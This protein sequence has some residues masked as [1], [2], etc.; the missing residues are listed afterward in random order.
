MPST[1]CFDFLRRHHHAGRVVRVAQIEEADLRGV[2]VGRIDH[3]RDV[4][5]V[6]LEQRQLDRVRLDVGGVL[7][8]RAVGRVG[9]DY[10]LAAHQERRADHLQ[11]FARSRGEQDVLRLHAMMLGDRFDDVAIGIAVPVG[12]LPRAVHRLHHLLRRAPVVL[13][14]GELDHAVVIRIVAAKSLRA[15]ERLRENFGFGPQAQCADG[16]RDTTK[17]LAAGKLLPDVHRS[18]PKVEKC[19]HEG[20]LVR[21]NFASQS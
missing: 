3:P 16:C 8:H 7:I 10:L 1:T 12:V 14:A 9:A 18:A 11:H 2:L 6:I 4:L 20:Y 21:P 13:V 17:K 15:G 5:A 19:P